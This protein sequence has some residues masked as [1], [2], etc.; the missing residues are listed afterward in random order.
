MLNTLASTRAPQRVYLGPNS[1]QSCTEITRM[2]DTLMTWTF[3]HA[4]LTRRLW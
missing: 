4:S 1:E 3:L 2:A